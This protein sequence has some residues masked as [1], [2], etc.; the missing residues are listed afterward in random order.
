MLTGGIE[1]ISHVAQKFHLHNM[2]ILD[3]DTRNVCPSLV[4]VRVV[5][6][7]FVAEHERDSQESVFAARAAIDGGI[8]HLE[9]IDI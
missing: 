9:T 4:G 2:N 7:E 6:E 1:T 3:I 5:V 8:D